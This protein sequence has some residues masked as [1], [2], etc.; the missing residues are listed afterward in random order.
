[1]SVEQNK[2]TLRRYY[3]TVLNQGDFT[4]WD[5]LVDKDYVIRSGGQETK[6]PEGGKRAFESRRAGAPDIR[7]T[8][9][10]MV[11]EN[12]NVVVRGAFKGTNTGPSQEL[13]QPTGKRFAMDYVALYRFKNGKI[14]EGWVLSDRLGRLQ[15][16]GITTIPT[17]V[18][19]PAR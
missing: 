1:M 4:K 2:A 3:E 18:A 15:R 17:P 5:E 10:E 6:G 7:I 19:A 11:A 8:F 9:D 14:A 13:P 12:D 16:F